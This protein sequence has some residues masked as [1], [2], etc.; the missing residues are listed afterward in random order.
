MVLL[1]PSRCARREDPVPLLRPFQLA[2]ANGWLRQCVSIWIVLG[3][4][5]GAKTH[6][7]GLGFHLP[8]GVGKVQNGLQTSPLS[9]DSLFELSS[10][11]YEPITIISRDCAGIGTPR[12]VQ[13]EFQERRFRRNTQRISKG[14][15]RGQF[16]SFAH[17]YGGSSCGYASR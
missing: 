11:R 6:P 17:Q 3:M 8:T 7:H 15:V 10:A 4:Q 13:E 14:H 1:V 2:P 5:D 16:T 12:P 9:G